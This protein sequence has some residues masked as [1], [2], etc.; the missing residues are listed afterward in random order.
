MGAAGTSSPDPAYAGDW[1]ANA[2]L[3]PLIV[4]VAVI[5][6]GWAAIPETVAAAPNARP[7]PAPDITAEGSGH[8]E[9]QNGAE[10]DGGHHDPPSPGRRTAHGVVSPRTNRD[11]V[12]LAMVNE[13]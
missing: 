7:Q 13:V 4:A 8:P 3:S 1:W 10:T 6:P 5:L 11:N 2:G 12:A 9:N